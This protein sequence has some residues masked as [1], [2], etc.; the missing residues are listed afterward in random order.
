[1]LSHELILTSLAEIRDASSHIIIYLL[2][3]IIYSERKMLLLHTPTTQSA[4]IHSSS[5]QTQLGEAFWEQFAMY[6]IVEYSQL[7]NA[8]SFLNIC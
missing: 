2:T 3:H 1:M 8:A 7:T 6:N 4:S 5:M